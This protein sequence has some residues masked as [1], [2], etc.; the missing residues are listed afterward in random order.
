MN[1]IRSFFVL[2]NERSVLRLWML[3]RLTRLTWIS[4][5]TTGRRHLL[6]SRR[7]RG[8]HWMIDHRRCHSWLL[9][10]LSFKKTFSRYQISFLLTNLIADN[11]TWTRL[12]LNLIWTGLIWMTTVINN[13]TRTLTCWRLWC[14]KQISKPS[15]DLA[16]SYHWL[17]IISK[18]W[19]I[20]SSLL[21]SNML[22]R[23]YNHIGLINHWLLWIHLTRMK[24]IWLSHSDLLSTWHQP[25]LSHRLVVGRTGLTR[26]MP[27][28]SLFKGVT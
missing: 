19:I 2:A 18:L 6:W 22:N 28:F 5:L 4:T 8:I 20:S 27:S 9:S 26:R 7:M 21:Y 12:H 3:S 10:R 11:V 25:W 17:W 23:R 15:Q 13:L 16:I 1:F 14:L 24:H